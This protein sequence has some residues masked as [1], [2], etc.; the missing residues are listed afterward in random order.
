[1]RDEVRLR[2]VE[3]DDLP[4]FFAHQRDPESVRMAAFPSRGREAFM[5]H[6]KRI[7]AD[8]TVVAR[9]ILWNGLVAGSVVCFEMSGQ[10]E[11]GYWVGRE[12]WGKGIATRALSQLLG[13][14]E[15]RPLWAHVAKH[16]AASVRVLEKCGFRI[17][18]DDKEFFQAGGQVIEGHVLKLEGGESG[19]P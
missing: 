7:Q 2:D 5:A 13:M 19:F 15:T 6:W 12:H 14:V 16:N 1:M 11:V 8:S 4:V 18:G 10:R 9:T 3:D 17:V